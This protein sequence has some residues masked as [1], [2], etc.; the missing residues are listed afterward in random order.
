[1]ITLFANRQSRQFF[2]NKGGENSMFTRFQHNTTNGEFEKL[3]MRNPDKEYDQELYRV[4][5]S[6]GSIN[7]N[8]D[9]VETIEEVA[10]KQKLFSFLNSMRT[11]FSNWIKYPGMTNVQIED[12]KISEAESK[13]KNT[14]AN[15]LIFDTQEKKGKTIDSESAYNKQLDELFGTQTNEGKRFDQVEQAQNFDT[16]GYFVDG[17]NTEFAGLYTPENYTNVIKGEVFDIPQEDSETGDLLQS[18]YDNLGVT[19]KDL[20]KGGETFDQAEQDTYQQ[21]FEKMRTLSVT[22]IQKIRNENMA[23]DE[24]DGQTVTQERLKQRKNAMEF[25]KSSL[26][27]SRTKIVA[28]ILSILAFITCITPTVA[29]FTKEGTQRFGESGNFGTYGFIEKNTGGVISTSEANALGL[30]EGMNGVKAGVGSLAVFFASLSYVG[31]IS[32][33]NSKSE[34]SKKEEK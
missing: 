17:I 25:L 33:L 11:T 32:G 6:E 13:A 34:N 20:L 30:N 21:P 18:I 28:G 27:H 24:F 16:S 10:P 2:D 31:I 26:T 12:A 3:N 22:E 23:S 14:S 5:D 1:M 29:G 8:K 15:Y 7:L 19:S 4:F 9:Q